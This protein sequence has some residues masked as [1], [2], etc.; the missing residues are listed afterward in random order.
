MARIADYT[1]QYCSCPW[2]KDEQA[3]LVWTHLPCWWRRRRWEFHPPVDSERI[4]LADCPDHQTNAPLD[5]IYRLHWPSNANIQTIRSLT[6]GCQ[7]GSQRWTRLCKISQAEQQRASIFNDANV[8]H[9]IWTPVNYWTSGETESSERLKRDRRCGR[10]R[11]P[12]VLTLRSSTCCCCCCTQVGQRQE[13]R[14]QASSP[15]TTQ[16]AVICW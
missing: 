12:G 6:L 9:T 1:T 14:R 2:P 16:S 11:R 15:R 8:T 13:R 4:Y 5:L 7:H 3:A 10:C